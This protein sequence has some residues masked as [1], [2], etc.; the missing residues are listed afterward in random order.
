MKNFFKKIVLK[1]FPELTPKK[2]VKFIGYEPGSQFEKML[3]AEINM[4]RRTKGLK[5]LKNDGIYASLQALKHSNYLA[6][7]IKKVGHENY[8]IR[9]QF[10]RETIG[11]ESVGEVVAYGYKD[12]IT[13]VD[14]WVNSPTY[15]AVLEKD[16][17]FVGIGYSKYKRTYFVVAML[18]K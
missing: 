14:T 6:N 7:V 5:D 9:V 13:L 8:G 1:M 16:F 11:A 18:W 10:L 15:K 12:P 3:V 2:G 17:D 4:H